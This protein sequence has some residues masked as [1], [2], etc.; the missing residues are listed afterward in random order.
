MLCAFTLGRLDELE[1]AMNHATTNE[2]DARGRLALEQVVTRV[3]VDLDAAAELLDLAERAEH[4]APNELSLDGLARSSLQAQ[5]HGEREVLVRL[6]R[7]GGECL[8]ATDAHVLRRLLAFAVARAHAFGAD[9]VTIRAAC[10]ETHATIEVSGSSPGDSG[11]ASIP[12]RL[13][14]R[15]DPTD[16]V[17]QA[18]ARAAGIGILVDTGS[19][20]LTV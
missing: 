9:H 19:I 14:R 3:S 8:M 11:L 13:V 17:V 7:E 5:P 1:A 12:M 16:A 6:V 10:A 15:I 20:A 18:A 4:A 2:L